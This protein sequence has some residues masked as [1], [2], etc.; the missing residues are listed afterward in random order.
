MNWVVNKDIMLLDVSTMESVGVV[1]FET[2]EFI[3]GNIFSVQDLADIDL[4]SFTLV[5]VVAALVLAEAL[6]LRLR[7]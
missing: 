4:L 7:V 5:M 6:R 3:L 1:A 2:S